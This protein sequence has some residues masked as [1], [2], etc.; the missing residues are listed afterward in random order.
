MTGM[1]KKT[2][3][4]ITEHPIEKLKSYIFTQAIE[5]SLIGLAVLGDEFFGFRFAR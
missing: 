4:A 1:T 5:A 3:T 2:V